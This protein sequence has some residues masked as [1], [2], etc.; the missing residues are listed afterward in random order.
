MPNLFIYVQGISFVTSWIHVTPTC[1]G[2]SHLARLRM[3]TCQGFSHLARLR[4]W[5]E[6]TWSWLRIMESRLNW[7]KTLMHKITRQ[8]STVPWTWWEEGTIILSGDV[9]REYHFSWVEFSILKWENNSNRKLLTRAWGHICDHA[10]RSPD[11]NLSCIC[12]LITHYT[13]MP[14]LICLVCHF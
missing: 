9:I 7:S 1:Q 13:W 4:M 11:Q 8:C 14:P 5:S 12:L 2:F 6:I 3:S 10:A